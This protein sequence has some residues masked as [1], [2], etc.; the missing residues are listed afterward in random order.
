[1]KKLCLILL[2]LIPVTLIAADIDFRAVDVNAFYTNGLIL[3]NRHWTNQSGLYRYQPGTG[4]VVNGQRGPAFTLRSDGSTLVGSNVFQD[5]NPAA[6]GIYSPYV[7]SMT[8][9]N[10]ANTVHGDWWAL[11]SEAYGVYGGARFIVQQGG[12]SL[13]QLIADNGP[14]VSSVVAESTPSTATRVRTE[15]G[16]TVR[17]EAST[18]ETNALS[19]NAVGQDWIFGGMTNGT[20][21]FK[22]KADGDLALI[23]SVIYSWP[24]SDGN[25]SGYVLTTTNTSGSLDWQPGLLSTAGTN[26]VMSIATNVVSTNSSIVNAGTNITVV[27]NGNLYTVSVTSLTNTI[28]AL[29]TNVVNQNGRIGPGTNNF[30]AKF[31]VVGGTNVGNSPLFSDNSNYVALISRPDGVSYTNSATNRMYGE[32]TGTGTNQYLE[33]IVPKG[34]NNESAHLRHLSPGQTDGRAGLTLNDSWTVW[35]QTNQGVGNPKGYITPTEDNAFDIGT[36]SSRVRS[37]TIGTG[38]LNVGVATAQ[39]AIKFANVGGGGSESYGIDG[40]GSSLAFWRATGITAAF[41]R[42]RNQN[43]LQFDLAGNYLG[44]G[45]GISNTVAFMGGNDQ[46]IAGIGLTGAIQLGTNNN[47][48]TTPAAAGFVGAPGV[49][50][51]KGGTDVRYIGGPASGTA[52]PGAVRLQTFE[53]LTNSSSS[54]NTVN[55]DRLYIAGE[56]QTLT[57]SSA[58]TVFNIAVPS[59]KTIGMI[60]MATTMAT[61]GTD[62]QS[63]V[64]SFAIAGVNK[65]GTVTTSISASVPTATLTSSGTLATTWTAVANGNSIDVKNS[66]V[67]SLSQTIL[68]CRWRVEVDSDGTS[69]I[70][71]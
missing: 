36:S 23:K 26:I 39:P 17:F 33:L 44:F 10:E 60:V 34:H 15:H 51:D 19:A 24:I 43:L 27:T 42:E 57:E 20:E 30:L 8:D 21:T 66:A 70:T 25:T 41:D 71:P 46:I 14:L 38:S 13:L 3:G 69:V 28:N 45:V 61:D 56:V 9:S 4:P 58:T 59:G 5:I 16:G 29:A 68:Q 2:L 49:G 12:S 22:V 53:P 54:F 62:H 47:S 1:M 63:V 67:S 11:D 18:A 35:P 40:V 37:M 6:V 55:K 52:R 50:T 32:Y 31:N 64:E 65:A 7:I 48:V